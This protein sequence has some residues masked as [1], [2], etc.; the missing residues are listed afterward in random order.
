MVTDME[1]ERIIDYWQKNSDMKE[2]VT[3]PWEKL[4][5]EPDGN[6]DEG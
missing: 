1:I 6:E 5:T 4:L 2:D 3:P